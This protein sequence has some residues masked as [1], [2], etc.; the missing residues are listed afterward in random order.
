MTKSAK[1]VQRVSCAGRALLGGVGARARG[2]HLRH[3]RRHLLRQRVRSVA[4]LHAECKTRKRMRSAL[5][6][7][8]QRTHSTGAPAAPPPTAPPAPPPR[9]PALRA[10]RT[11]VSARKRGSRTRRVPAAPLAVGLAP[12]SCARR[13]VR[14]HIIAPRRHSP[15]YAR[16]ASSSARCDSS[17]SRATSAVYCP[18]QS[19]GKRGANRRQRQPPGDRA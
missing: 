1:S 10:A 16:A 9:R 5:L 19:R 11:G 2:L 6:A 3:Q 12:R 17:R 7:R 14:R 8:L 13:D 15:G 4:S 18:A